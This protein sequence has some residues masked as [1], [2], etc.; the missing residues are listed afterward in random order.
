MLNWEFITKE[1]YD[2]LPTSEKSF[3]KLFFI[4][5]NNQ[6]FCG[7]SKF[8][9]SIV[10]YKNNPTTTVGN[11]IYI[12]G[13]TLEGKIWSK[14]KWITIINPVKKKSNTTI[15]TN[16]IEIVKY[17]SNKNKLIVSLKDGTTNTIELNDIYIDF[18]YDEETEDLLIERCSAVIYE[19]GELINLTPFIHICI[20]YVDNKIILYFEN[21]D[22]YIT[23]NTKEILD[24]YA[25]ELCY[26]IVITGNKFTADSV[27]YSNDKNKRVLNNGLYI[28]FNYNRLESSLFNTF[29]YNSTNS[30]ALLS[31]DISD[32]TIYQI[33]TALESSIDN[34]MLKVGS[35]YT[36]EILVADDSGDAYPSGVKVGG[37]KLKNEPTDSLVATEQAVIAYIKENTISKDKIST[38]DQIPDNEKNASDDMVASEK[39]MIKAISWNI[40]Y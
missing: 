27:L 36:G 37:S 28:V 32:E 3:D 25:D 22:E 9:E 17:S 14:S 2:N 38:S 24:S 12:N 23:L 8:S 4:K 21:S 16:I 15:D 34:K 19:T 20:Q 26:A 31:E 10:V 1:A 40:I 13:E 6:L 39:S 11:K 18:V 29:S 33:R 7:T 30:T 5:D 35:G